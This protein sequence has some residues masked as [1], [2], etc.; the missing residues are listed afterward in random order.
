MANHKL[1][2]DEYWLLL[3]QIYLKRPQGV[4]PLYSRPVVDLALE[5]HI[6]PD[7]LYRQ[8]FKLRQLDTP[9]MQQLWDTYAHHPKRLAREVDLLRQMNGFGNSDDFYAGVT[10]NE[11]WEKDFKPVASAGGHVPVTPVMLIVI[12]DLYFRLIPDTMVPDTPEIIDLAKHIGLTP[13]EVAEVMEV[14][15]FCDPLLSHEDIMIHPLLTPCM[16]IW[17]R[18]G[19]EP[20]EKLA[21]LSAQLKAYWQKA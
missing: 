19:N 16:Q 2:H 12:L 11:S 7:F 15:R 13:V 4:K 3:M 10:V 8:L 20:P 9:R 18:F 1:W 6:A 14:Y 5:L 17:K 21:A